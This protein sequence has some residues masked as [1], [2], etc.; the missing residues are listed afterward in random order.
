MIRSFNNLSTDLRETAVNR[1][2]ESLL[3]SILDG[4]IRFNDQANQDD[5]QARI[6]VAYSKADKMQT[7][8][9]A[10]EYIMETCG[11]ELRGMAQ[12]DAEDA[13]YPTTEQFIYL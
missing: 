5:L 12:Y 1:C 13:L 11:E 2:L 7:P 9:F 3:T 4:S 6:D 8:W 10:S